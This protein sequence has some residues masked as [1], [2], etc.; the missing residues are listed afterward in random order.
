MTTPGQDATPTTRKNHPPPPDDE[1]ATITT[2]I[3]TTRYVFN[4]PRKHHGEGWQDFLGE[5]WIEAQRRLKYY[6]PARQ[7]LQKYIQATCCLGLQR[8][9][10][11]RDGAQ[12]RK[13]T[14]HEAYD[15]RY[16]PGSS[17]N[18]PATMAMANE[19]A[20]LLHRAVAGLP[21]K[22]R[23]T[24]IE[25]VIEQRPIADILERNPTMKEATVYSRVRKGIEMLR[26]VLRD[27]P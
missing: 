15:D 21:G 17:N 27:H 1:A 12:K 25:Y 19:Q 16:I 5:A 26:E 13:H 14:K 6:D 22:V 23:K 7:P 8:D 11:R 10:Y 20:A 18:D 24:L 9:R 4:H 2:V 3:T